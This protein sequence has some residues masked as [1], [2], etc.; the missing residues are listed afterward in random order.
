MRTSILAVA[1]LSAVLAG[2]AARAWGD[3]TPEIRPYVG[4]FVPTGDQRDVL[5]DAVLVGGQAG[6]EVAQWLHVIGNFGYSGNKAKAQLNR[7]DVHIYAYDAGVEAFHITKLQNYFQMR[8]FLGIGAGARTYDPKAGSA[9]T[10]VAGY[11]ALGT[12]LQSGNVAIRLEGRDYL[13]RFKGLTGD[14]GTKTRND[15]MFMLGAA[16]H[17]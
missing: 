5:K 1:L 14:L 2:G 12:E 4:V 16:F 15:M 13:T 3:V 10:N 17:W 6:V 9:Q 11:G 8:P 7:K